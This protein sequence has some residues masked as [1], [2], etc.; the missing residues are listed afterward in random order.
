MKDASAVLDGRILNS[1]TSPAAASAPA[2][3]INTVSPLFTVCDVTGAVTAAP[4]VGTLNVRL[5]RRGRGDRDQHRER[6]REGGGDGEAV[7][8]QLC[9]VFAR[10]YGAERCLRAAPR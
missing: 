4:V 1:T 10:C 9:Y 8:S 2:S 6:Y 5:G 3:A 7:G